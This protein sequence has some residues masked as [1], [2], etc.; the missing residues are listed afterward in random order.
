M[1]HNFELRHNRSIIQPC[2]RKVVQELCRDSV[3]KGQMLE[4]AIEELL[5]GLCRLITYVIK[6]LDCVALRV[7]EHA[8]VQYIDDTG[9]FRHLDPS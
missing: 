7:D 5:V 3:W 4:R 8:V 9:T 6:E 2:D 1:T